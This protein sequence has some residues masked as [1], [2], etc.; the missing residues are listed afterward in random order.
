[1]EERY[2]LNLVTAGIG[3]LVDRYVNES[4]IRL[5]GTLDYA[6]ATL[7]ANDQYKP[8]HLRVDVDGARMGVYEVTVGAV[9]TGRYAG[10]GMHFSPMARIAAGVF[11]VVVIEAA[12]IGKSLGVGRM[13]YSAT[14]LSSPL[15]HHARGK[16]VE[17][18]PL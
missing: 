14:H 13:L 1:R 5:G 11:E 9:C 4:K 6:V 12:P 2:F 17:L 3:G 10:G 8:A 7:R 15:V 16:R 18:T